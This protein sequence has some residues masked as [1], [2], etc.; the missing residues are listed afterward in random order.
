MQHSHVAKYELTTSWDA[1]NSTACRGEKKNQVLHFSFQVQQ[2]GS[3]EQDCIFLVCLYTFSHLA[4]ERSFA[5]KSSARSICA[6]TWRKMHMYCTSNYINIKIYVPE[7]IKPRTE[8]CPSGGVC[9]AIALTGSAVSKR[10]ILPLHNSN[11]AY[12]LLVFCNST[13]VWF[14]FM[15]LSFQQ[16]YL[17]SDNI[18]IL[19]SFKLFLTEHWKFF[20]W[21]IFYG[22]QW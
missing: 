20:R 6:V 19:D 21:L 14:H 9:R 7:N 3:E 18:W 8:P 15:T 1:S 13:E 5:H 11:S 22:V 16:S 12:L 10:R 4:K 2:K 17:I